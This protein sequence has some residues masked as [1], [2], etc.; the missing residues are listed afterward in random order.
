VGKKRIADTSKESKKVKISGLKGGQRVVDMDRV[1]ETEGTEVTEKTEKPVATPTLPSTPSLPSTPP[2][3]SPRLRGAAYRAA[4]T[5]IDPHRLYPVAEAIKLIKEVSLSQFAGTAEAH[6]VVTR[7]GLAGEAKLPYF[8]AKS[9]K[10]AIADSQV[11]EK[12]KEGKIDFDVLLA[13]PAEMPKLLPFAK[14]LGPKGLLPNPKNG[15]LVDNPGEAAKKYQSEA[16]AFKTEKDFPLIHTVFGKISQKEEEL[17]E[18]LKA[19]I[20]AIGLVNIKKLVIKPTMGPGIK[21]DASE[22]AR[23]ASDGGGGKKKGGG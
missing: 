10:V 23:P 7:K 2:R 15:T 6:L 9:K 12:I 20:A 16:L 3:R 1:E 14:I 19:L 8:K 4:R 17:A 13:S 22:V 5:K 18:N 21:I 11:I